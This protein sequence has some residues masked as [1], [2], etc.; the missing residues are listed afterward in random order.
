MT[1]VTGAMIWDTTFQIT[2]TSLNLAAIKLTLNNEIML[3]SSLSPGDGS[4]QGFHLLKLNQDGDSLFAAK[5]PLTGYYYFIDINFPSEDQIKLLGSMSGV[6]Q[7]ACFMMSTDSIGVIQTSR[8]YHRSEY[9]WIRDAS[10]TSDGGGI[11]CGYYDKGQREFAGLLIKLDAQGNFL[12]EQKFEDANAS[13]ELN[14]VVEYSGGGY[15]ISGISES[16]VGRNTDF[17]LIKT[18]RNGNLSDN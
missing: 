1:D 18:D 12:W 15:V 4:G 7:F 14:S 16:V 10:F 11:F 9:F 8:F 2:D 3:L 5:V 13:I 17:L 6:N